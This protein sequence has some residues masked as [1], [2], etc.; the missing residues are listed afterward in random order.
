MVSK[1]Q[2]YTQFQSKVAVLQDQIE[3]IKSTSS[4]AG[5]RQGAIDVVLAGIS[6]LQNEVAD[7]AE[8]TPSYDRRQYSLA[9]KGIQDKLNETRAALA[10]KSR[11]QFKRTTAAVQH[12]DMG[13]PQ[14]DPR[15]L[16]ALLNST[17]SPVAA[18]K[19]DSEKDYNRDISRPTGTNARLPSFTAAKQISIT[20]QSGVHVIVPESGSEATAAG[21]LTSISDCVVDFTA[22]T[23]T[24]P[25]PG[26]AMRDV[27]K[28][29]VVAGRVAGPVHITGVSDSVLV[30]VAHQVRIH[31]CKNVDIYLY[32]TSHPIIEDCSGMRFAPLP[33]FYTTDA[34]DKE[35]NQWSQVDDFKW[36]KA[37]HSPNWT[38]L[39]EA[40]MV[41]DTKWAT[42]TS[43]GKGTVVDVLKDFG[44]SP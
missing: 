19:A 23:K 24:R 5:E 18:A 4:I 3:Q 9:I 15:L 31:E 7:V 29:V 43:E 36:L 30:I 10:P 12:V 20:N 6:K 1:Q 2:F 39:S 34:D 17:H 42:V 13:K 40:Q 26:L 28:S 33:A 27:K 38:T 32:C 16:P 11:F 21:S 14:N 41:D 22:P 44:I 37:T 25:F 35:K 8:D